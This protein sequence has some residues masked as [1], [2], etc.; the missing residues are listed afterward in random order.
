MDGARRKTIG[1]DGWCLITLVCFFPPVRNPP[2]SFSSTRS[3]DSRLTQHKSYANK[4]A[5][6]KSSYLLSFLCISRSSTRYRVLIVP[7]HV[8][9]R[10]PFLM[11]RIRFI[12]RCTWSEENL[13]ELYVKMYARDLQK[14]R[15]HCC[16][17][18]PNF[19][20]IR[21]EKISNSV[22]FVFVVYDWLNAIRISGTKTVH[23]H[24]VR[25]HR[26]IATNRRNEPAFSKYPVK[27]LLIESC[28][29]SK[30]LSY[31]RESERECG[32]RV[33]KKFIRCD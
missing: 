33:G 18:L 19:I 25:F 17:R 14:L 30:G 21:K 16:P 27:L 3:L 5:L 4:G 31:D 7:M 8:F 15:Y 9:V 29:V 32:K 23:P 28:L 11:N 1:R 6:C 10:K 22:R 13:F 26:C 12:H 20:S 24:L 2:S